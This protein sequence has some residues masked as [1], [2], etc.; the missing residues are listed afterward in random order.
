MQV[1]GVVAPPPL[2]ALATPAVVPD[3]G[4]VIAGH[5]FS[6][7]VA[8][9]APLF[10]GHVMAQ[11][12]Y[13][14]AALTAPSVATLVPAA[15]ATTHP[16]VA[17]SAMVFASHTFSTAVTVNTWPCVHVIPHE[18]QPVA[19]AMVPSVVT[20]VATAVATVHPKAAQSPADD[21]AVHAFSTAFTANVVPPVHVMPQETHPVCAPMVPSPDTEFALAVT[22][23]QPKVFQSLAADF[24]VHVFSVHEPND[25][26][27]P[28]DGQ[29]VAAH[30]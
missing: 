11:L 28:V 17:H 7:T 16:A 25:G 15:S 24:W 4:V 22:T 8:T 10:V 30:V 18:A 20:V 3:A 5:W 1:C 23:A 21:F 6:T 27:V 14:G 26:V 9:N 29:V 19:A 12:A 2:Q 13:P